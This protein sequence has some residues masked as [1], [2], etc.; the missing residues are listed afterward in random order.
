MKLIEG[1]WSDRRPFWTNNRQNF[2]TELFLFVWVSRHE[3]KQKW[4][5]VRRLVEKSL[6]N[7]ELFLGY[8]VWIHGIDA[9]H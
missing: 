7:T 9:S 2:L 5:C 4:S 8:K 3:V 1:S 6:I